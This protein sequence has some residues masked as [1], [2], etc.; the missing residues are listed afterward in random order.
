M[1]YK[2]L[3]LATI[4]CLCVLTVALRG[5]IPEKTYNDSE[6]PASS[7]RATVVYYRPDAGDGWHVSAN[8]IDTQTSLVSGEQP[9]Q[10]VILYIPDQY[11]PTEPG[12]VRWASVT[13]TLTSNS[14]LQYEMF[15]FS[16]NES[17]ALVVDAQGPVFLSHVETFTDIYRLDAAPKQ[18]MPR[19]DA[20][21]LLEPFLNDFSIV[22]TKNGLEPGGF[23]FFKLDSIE[24][25]SSSTPTTTPVIPTLEELAW[26]TTGVAVG[27]IVIPTVLLSILAF[28]LGRE[29]NRFQRIFLGT[30][31]F[32]GILVRLAVAPFTGHPYDMEVWTQ[33]ARL[34]YESGVIGIRFFPLPFMYY[35]LLVAYSP[36]AL[37]RTFGFQD[38]TFL[39][40]VSGMIESVFIKAPFMISDA[41][42][43]YI[44]VKIFS[45]LDTTRHDS[46][47]CMAFA[48]MY[49]LN[50]LAIYLS[51]VWG[52][53]DTIAVSL[54]LGGIYLGLLR[55]R[56]LLSALSFAVSGLTK[57]FGFLG[58]IPLFVSPMR[59]NRCLNVLATAGMTLGLSILLYLPLM[60]ASTVQEVPEIAL[61]FFRGRAGLGSNTPYV[62]GASYMSYL[63]VLGFNIEPLWLAYIL[64][65]LVLA[66]SILYAQRMRNSPG[67]ARFALTLRYLA[68][69]FLVFYLVFFRV[70]EQYYLWVIP[71]L[72]MYSYVKRATAPG[73]VALIL[74][75]TLIPPLL[76]TVVAGA[77]YYY[78]VSLNFPVDMAM[79]TL[80]AS[81]LVVCGLISVADLKG[82]LVVFEA[83]RGIAALAGPALWFSFTL[84]YYAYYGAPFLGVIWYPISIA[85]ILTATT[86]LYKR[87][88]S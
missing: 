1:R 7:V 86:F 65:A 40:H 68:A 59:G 31:L 46:R 27:I 9:F 72:I 5:A 88:R 11:K 19:T 39:G 34:F 76:G 50:P 79:L 52:M 63:S 81:T 6:I 24:L 13:Y 49:F 54:L 71:I 67:E 69:V 48:L 20:L 43:L 17:L 57:G 23:S 25:M 47:R 16:R 64:V 38:P 2:C 29:S 78:G 26:M 51:S 73:F 32:Y 83:D 3:A 84:A 41:L 75:I 35:V 4:I 33:S 60:G 61:Q 18:Q 70:Y 74:S 55:D 22:I 58:L 8:R 10:A 42:S 66:I 62:A 30:L 12:S 77:A 45:R 28:R 44:L 14:K 36:Y 37:I 87:L 56:S 53:Y 85:I 82:R 80:L 15:L 21:M